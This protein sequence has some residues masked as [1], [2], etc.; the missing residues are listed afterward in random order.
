[1]PTSMR[2]SDSHGAG[3]KMRGVQINP[4]VAIVCGLLLVGVLTYFFWIRPEMQIAKAKADWTSPEAV[5]LRSPEGRPQN[6]THEQFVASL[7]S[8]EQHLANGNTRHHG[9]EGTTP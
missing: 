3:A 4:I 8:K 7:R 5:K 6:P 9:A 1:M 2:P